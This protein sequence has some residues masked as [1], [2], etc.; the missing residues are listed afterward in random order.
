ME[1]DPRVFRCAVV[2]AGCSAV[3]QAHNLTTFLNTCLHRWLV[4]CWLRRRGG[5]RCRLQLHPLCCNVTDRVAFLCALLTCR[6]SLDEVVR[7]FTAGAVRPQVRSPQRLGLSGI[8]G[9][10]AWTP[11]CRRF[12]LNSGLQAG[13]QAGGQA[14]SSEGRSQSSL[15]SAHCSSALLIRSSFSFVPHSDQPPLC[16]GGGARRLPRPDQ[17]PGVLWMAAVAVQF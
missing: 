15:V 9:I 12:E 16:A 13:R 7:L 3:G 17:P 8:R 14:G 6:K 2:G 1:K 11:C 5:L 4:S 10:L